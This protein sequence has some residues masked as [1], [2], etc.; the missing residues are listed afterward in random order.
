MLG[1]G[2]GCTYSAGG[3]AKP[4]SQEGNSAIFKVREY[5]LP[6]ES[7]EFRLR[8]GRLSPN[9]IKMRKGKKAWCRLADRGDDM[10]L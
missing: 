4:A 1:V 3:L 8:Q 5:S 7:R 6:G 2:R 10:R 9:I